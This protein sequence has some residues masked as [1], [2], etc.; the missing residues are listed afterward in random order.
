LVGEEPAG[1]FVAQVV[2]VQVDLSKLLAVDSSPR[3][4]AF[5][6]VAIRFGRKQDL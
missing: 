3:F 5:R 4:R 6:V 1:A 2:P